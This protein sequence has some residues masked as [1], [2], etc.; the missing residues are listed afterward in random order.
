MNELLEELL[1]L[2]L[3][4]PVPVLARRRCCSRR[5]AAARVGDVVIAAASVAARVD[6]IA[7]AAAATAARVGDVVEAAAIAVARARSTAA[8]GG[9][10][11]AAGCAA[12]VAAG[13]TAS[14]GA[15]AA[16]PGPAAAAGP[17]LPLPRCRCRWSR[18]RCSR[19]F[20]YRLRC[21]RRCRWLPP[22]LLVVPVPVPTPLVPV[23]PAP[24][25]LLVAL[26]VSP[27]PLLP[28]RRS[29][30][31]CCC[32]WTVDDPSVPDPVTLSPTVFL[33]DATTPSVGAYSFV[34]ESVWRAFSTV[35][36]ALL[37]L[38]SALITVDVFGGA[39]LTSLAASVDCS[40]SSALARL[41]CACA[42]VCS[43]RSL[44][45][46]SVFFAFA[47]V[48]RALSIDCWPL[49][50]CAAWLFCAVEDRIAVLDHLRFGGLERRFGRA[51]L[52]FGR[53][54]LLFAGR[55]L[56]PFGWRAAPSLLRA[57]A[58]ASTT[59][60]SSVPRW[61]MSWST[62]SC[63]L[64][65]STATDCSVLFSE[66]SAC[67][68]VAAAD[69]ASDF[70]RLPVLPQR[71]LRGGDRRARLLGADL[72]LALFGGRESLERVLIV[73]FGGR[74]LDFRR[75]QARFGA[76]RADFGQQLAAF[77]VVADAH[78][79]PGECS[80][81]S[82]VDADFARGRKRCRCPR[83]STGRRPARLWRSG[84]TLA[85]LPEAGPTT[86]AAATIAPMQ[87]RPGGS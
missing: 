50:V 29:R 52:R 25:S 87:T 10:A 37:T 27:V 5:R 56:G 43:L 61:L 31:S 38:F 53:A 33:I 81:R 79:Q 22:P 85:W 45:D 35:S 63:W 78:E 54:D 60:F 7:I 41:V 76:G 74:E 68:T 46:A 3:L 39:A 36:C 28:V 57:A 11:R 13:A 44:V 30:P 62:A 19:W 9:A 49:I 15:A 2:S 51:D 21:S 69:A 1:L 65:A 12:V 16:A 77:D 32:H 26:P 14:G 83:P 6:G 42:I 8:F 20:R 86:S 82:E 66:T 84:V 59:A 34:S 40:D 47:T 18:R 23:L 24:V 17:R 67:A 72:S 58:L 55:R 80:A 48:L 64:F 71:L 70:G 73:G 75:A 4:A